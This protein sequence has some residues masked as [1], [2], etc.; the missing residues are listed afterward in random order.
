M[1]ALFMPFECKNYSEDPRNPELDQ[2]QGR[3]DNVRGRIGVLVCRNVGNKSL[4]ADRCNDVT[5][6]GNGVI[7]WIEDSDLV[8]LLRNSQDKRIHWDLL[9][10]RA[11]FILER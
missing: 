8:A 9:D 7:L 1:S 2:L 11:R 6:Q 3:F 4:M 10:E 5:R